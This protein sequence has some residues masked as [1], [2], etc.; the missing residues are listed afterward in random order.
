LSWPERRRHP[1][2]ARKLLPS[3]KEYGC[4]RREREDAWVSTVIGIWRRIG[5]KA[6][7]KKRMRRSAQSS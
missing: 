2:K 1:G 3:G 7:E 6:G 4:G 5:K